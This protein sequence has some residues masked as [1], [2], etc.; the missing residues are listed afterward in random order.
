[1]RIALAQINPIVGDLHGNVSKIVDFAERAVQQ[2]AD[3]VVYPELCVTGYPPFDLLESEFFVSSV[4]DALAE[5][6]DRVPKDT[7]VIVGAPIRNTAATGKRLFNAAILFENGQRV[8]TYRKQ[9]LP[10]YDVFDEYRYFEP[11]DSCD[12]IE[13]SG[14]KFGLHVC[15][16]M[17]NNNRYLFFFF[18]LILEKKK[19]P[20]NN[21]EAIISC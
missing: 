15:E 21:F 6:G 10:T 11:A 4:E 1:M 2:G 16:D 3:L 9:L 12:M 7:G 18:F 19:T 8:A 17:W 13:W 20:L 5:I 14:V